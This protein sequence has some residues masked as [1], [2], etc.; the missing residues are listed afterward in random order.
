MRSHIWQELYI[1][2]ILQGQGADGVF[3][4]DDVG[5]SLRPKPPRVASLDLLQA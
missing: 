4:V 3:W 5:D 2:L 1:L